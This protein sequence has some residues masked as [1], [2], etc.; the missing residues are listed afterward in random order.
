MLHGSKETR[1]SQ[2]LKTLERLNADELRIEQYI[3]NPANYPIHNE[4]RERLLDIRAA[5]A[6]RKKQI[7]E[8]LG[9]LPPHSGYRDQ[10]HTEAEMGTSGEGRSKSAEFA[11]A[12]YRWVP[13]QQM[14]N[15]VPVEKTPP[16]EVTKSEPQPEPEYE[17]V[18]GHKQA[19][20]KGR[21]DLI[22]AEVLDRVAEI[23][24]IGAERYGIDN[25]RG[26]PFHQHINHLLFHANKARTLDT[27]EDHLAHA[28]C[29]AMFAWTVGHQ[30]DSGCKP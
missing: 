28:I 6:I 24:A 19:K 4:V 16:A 11:S 26:I 3:D 8:E 18:H 5:K 30:K 21:Y 1:L 29:R 2:M 9:L 7:A 23:L 13:Y 10:A 15:E 17:F 20:I 12:F 27:S 25:W 22:P 14:V